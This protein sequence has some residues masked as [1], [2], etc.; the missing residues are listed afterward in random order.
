MF[1][2]ELSRRHALSVAAFAVGALLLAIP[3]TARPAA[4]AEQDDEPAGGQFFLTGDATHE[5]GVLEQG[6]AAEHLVQVALSA[7]VT[8]A[9]GEPFSLSLEFDPRLYDTSDGLIVERGTNLTFV[10]LS[11][12]SLLS[13]TRTIVTADVP[14]LEG[15]ERTPRAEA[16]LSLPLRPADRYPGDDIGPVTDTALTVTLTDGR[17]A[18]TTWGTTATTPLA[19]V[20]GVELSAGWSDLAVTQEGDLRQYRVPTT[21]RCASVG[22]GSVPGGAVLTVT[23]DGT[24]TTPPSLTSALIDDAEGDVS[25]FTVTDESVDGTRLLHVALPDTLPAGSTV[26][27]LFEPAPVTARSRPKV[28]SIHVA[29]VTLAAPEQPTARRRTTGVDVAVDISPSGTPLTTDAATGTI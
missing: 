19:A 28:T 7:A 27:L 22:P 25:R 9:A 10:A 1:Q 3:V 8:G 4:A 14:A 2:T 18:R 26:T 5:I 13:P 24:L 16:A 20:W 12:P 17:S 29:T 15:S 11:E 6:F 23:L 21:V